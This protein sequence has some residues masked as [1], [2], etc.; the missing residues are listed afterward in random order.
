[1]KKEIKRTL[2][3]TARLMMLAISA[4]MSAYQLYKTVKS[5]DELESEFSIKD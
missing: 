2:I 4:G 3:Y 1:M 5:M